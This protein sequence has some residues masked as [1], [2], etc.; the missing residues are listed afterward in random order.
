MGFLAIIPSLMI[1]VGIFQMAKT[2]VNGK[3]E[4]K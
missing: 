2:L 1:A 3:K 4:K